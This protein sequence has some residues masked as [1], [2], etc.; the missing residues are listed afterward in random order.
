MRIM[1]NM[2]PAI[3][4]LLVVAGAASPALAQWNSAVGGNAVRSGYVDA[5][6]PTTPDRLWDGVRFTRYVRPVA[7]DNG[8]VYAQWNQSG[9]SFN[10]VVAF[11][12][13]SGTELWSVEVPTAGSNPSSERSRVTGV[14]D[15]V[16]YLTRSSSISNPLPIYAY[17]AAT[18]AGPL[19]TSQA[20]VTESSQQSVTFA[21]NGDLIVAGPNGS[22][23]LIRINKNDGTTVWTADV[24][25]PVDDANG[26][27]VCNDTVYA[28]DVVG[29][30]VVGVKA[31]DLAT[32]AA[33]Y[34]SED[35]P[36]GGPAV[37]QGLFCGN[38]GK[39]YAFRAGDDNNM[40]YL[41]ALEDTG[42][43]LVTV[44][45]Y[46]AGYGW[47]STHGVGP[48]GSIYTHDRDGH[49]IRLDQNT[50]LLLA[51]SAS[52]IP[53][54]SDW[55]FSPRSAVDAD[56]NVFISS[57]SYSSGYISAF[58]VNMNLLWSEYVD[59]QSLTGPALGANGELVV[60]TRYQ[61]M[62]VYGTPAN[63]PVP[64]IKVNGQDGPLSVTTSDLVNVTISLDPGDQ[65][66]LFADWWV[67]MEKDIAGTWWCRYTGSVPQW[68]KAPVPIP[69]AG[70]RLLNFSN[71]EVLA[72]R[73]L[74][75]G[76]YTWTFSVDDK[77]GTLE[78]TYTDS[79]V[80]TVN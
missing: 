76:T 63:N 71:Y 13:A 18:G 39:V 29:S 60:Q 43:A 34:Q 77:N 24:T 9:S 72:P 32:G 20:L 17:D 30:W 37:Q 28:W 19:W 26:A 14:R 54:G 58:D 21:P 55:D 12:I 16:V 15:G 75:M 8:I 51:R 4:M 23:G 79:V 38:D 57:G 45:T 6:G 66:G 25:H 2:L 11:D 36:Q 44:W 61:G 5:V 69:F 67:Y 73:T 62:I 80:L 35:M 70:A 65:L 3:A 7:V 59:T 33:K 56:G 40:H 22:S 52:P 74:P 50:G 1:K 31:F 68:Y 53:G 27:V 10:E 78:D 47:A 41:Y 46:L 42:T 48:D 64:D 49:A